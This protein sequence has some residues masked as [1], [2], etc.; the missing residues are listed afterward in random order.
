MAAVVRSRLADGNFAELIDSGGEKSQGR[1]PLQ[2]QGKND[3][4]RIGSLGA[5]R[6]FFEVSVRRRCGNDDP[7]GDAGYRATIEKASIRDGD[8]IHESFRVVLQ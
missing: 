8:A 1:A 4:G 3:S 6:R 2:T 5:F 7:P